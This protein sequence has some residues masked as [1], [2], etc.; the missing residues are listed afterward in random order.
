MCNASAEPEKGGNCVRSPGFNEGKG[1][2]NRAA[3]EPDTGEN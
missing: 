1:T 3:G 2:V